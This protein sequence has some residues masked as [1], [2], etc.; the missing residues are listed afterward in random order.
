[1]THE[2]TSDAR[3]PED[4]FVGAAENA[5]IK[6]LERLLLG[7]IDVNCRHSTW[8]Y[9]ALHRAASMGSSK[10]VEFL[11]ERGADINCLDRNDM[12]PLM[13]ACSKGKKKGSQVALLLIKRGALA[14]YTREED[15]MTALKFALWGQCSSEVFEALRPA[16][17]QLPEAGF[18]I[19][20]LK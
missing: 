5:D 7:G 13:C 18:P 1:M 15:G 8:R 9:T 10:T 3:P 2:E 20:I 6:V 11:L 12:T 17:A 4:C 16:G 19:V 14:T